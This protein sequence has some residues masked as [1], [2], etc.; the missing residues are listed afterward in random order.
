MKTDRLMSIILTLLEKERVSAQALAEMFEVSTRTIYR[1]IEAINMAGIPIV[2]TSGAGGGIEIL[3]SYKVDKQ[4]FS[5]ADLSSI[6]MGLTSLTGMVQG[7]EIANALAKVKSFIPLDKAREIQRMA[8]QV[9]VDSSPWMC[10]RNTQPYLEAIRSALQA[11]KLLSLGYTDHKGNKTLRIVEPYQLIL[12]NSHWY[13]YAYCQYRQD[14][15]M[16]KLS[17]IAAPQVQEEGFTPRDFPKPALHYPAPVE[18]IILTLRIH[19]SLLEQLLD[20]CPYEDFTPDGDTHYLLSFPFI[21]NDYSYQQ[22]LGFGE[23][24]ECLAP[25]HI[26]HEIKQRIARMA[27]LYGE[28]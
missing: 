5:S 3:P 17:R 10:N 14:Y 23:K 7:D 19:Q 13:L 20:F 8:S 1:D 25:P 16:F 12:K 26:R 22:L 4:V 2:A 18:S 24:C 11:H 27:A 15:R 6:L 28:E 9:Y 21:E